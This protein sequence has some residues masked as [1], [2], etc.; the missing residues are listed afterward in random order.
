MLL[1]IIAACSCRSLPAQ[2]LKPVYQ[3][4]HSSVAVVLTAGTA[5][6]ASAGQQPVVTSGIGSAVLIS[7]DGKLATAAHVAETADVLVVQF[8]NGHRS[9][10]RVVGSVQ[11]ADIALLQLEDPPGDD[12]AVATLGDS[13]AMEVGD[14]V[15]VVGAPLGVVHTMTTGYIS[16]RRAHEGVALIDRADL[17]QTDA[18][19]NP[20]NSGGPMFNMAGEV[21]GIVSHI[22]TRTGGSQGLG[23]AVSSR[24]VKKLLLERSAFWVGVGG[25]QVTVTLARALQLPVDSLG[26]VLVEQASSSSPLVRGLGVRAGKIRAAIDGEELVLG[27][28]VIMRA[29]G[30]RLS[31]PRAYDA[32]RE[33]LD[34]LEPGGEITL[35]IYRQGEVRELR[36]ILRPTA[37]APWRIVPADE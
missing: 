19:I 10:A 37:R 35:T 21:V 16:A 31:G 23:F 25:R 14:R 11:R 30:V 17:L 15:F 7:R 12:I 34:A 22:M 24:T 32:V 36:G 20:G 26:G 27:G 28:D 13:D 6:P 18:A 2:E 8:V 33:K 1:T 29:M 4:V 5:A 3:R 9:S